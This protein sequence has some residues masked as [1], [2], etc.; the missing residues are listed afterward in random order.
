MKFSPQS[1]YNKARLRSEEERIMK[2]FFHLFFSIVAGLGLHTQAFAHEYRGFS[3]SPDLDISAES[4]GVA[5]EASIT[6]MAVHLAKHIELIQASDLSQPEQAKEL[7]ILGQRT[8]ERGIFNN[9]E[10]YFVLVNP[11]GYIANH[12][13]YPDLH[14]KKYFPS[15]EFKDRDGMTTGTMETLLASEAPTCVNY[16]YGGEDRVACAMGVRVFSAGGA[17]IN[18]MGFHHA[19]DDYDLIEEDNP[20]CDVPLYSLPVTAGQVDGEQDPQR[21]E[22]LLV[23]Y[24]KAVAEKFKQRSGATALQ[25]FQQDPA[26]VALGG[27]LVPDSTPEQV[28]AAAKELGERSVRISLGTTSCLGSG[29]YKEGSIYAFMFAPEDG[30]AVING[31]DFHR[32]GVSVSLT[33]PDPIQCD[34]AN[35]LEA[36]RNAATNGSGNLMDLAEGNSGFVTY[37]WKN[38]TLTDDGNQNYLEKGEI[39]GFSIKKSYFEVVDITPPELATLG[40]PPLWRIVGSGIYLDDAEYCEEGDEGCAIASTAPVSGSALL[41]LLVIA[42]VVLSV[43]A[44]RQRKKLDI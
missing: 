3:H 39:P 30:T 35:L 10:V 21:K 29:D 28:E 12:G 26:L 20:N 32:Y 22:E 4:V 33:D 31:L 43:V 1:C 13:I 18:L 5:D 38:P 44:G 11:E 16:H 37:H 9:G 15:F 27:G 2:V 19:R 14:F 24:V 8:R 25:L 34:G 17:V 36:F 41:N 23:E 40:T 7:V 42:A 6:K